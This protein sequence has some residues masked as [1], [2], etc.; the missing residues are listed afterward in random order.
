MTTTSPHFDHYRA[1]QT[2][3]YYAV[4]NM[5]THNADYRCDRDECRAPAEFEVG[6][7]DS[8]GGLVA[9]VLA[10]ACVEHLGAQV[11]HACEF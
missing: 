2:I 5:N 7:A 10:Y 8:G 9:D 6:C 11:R 4:V 3:T 1:A